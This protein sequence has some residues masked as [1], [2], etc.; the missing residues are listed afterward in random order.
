M[1]PSLI[2]RKIYPYFKSG[3]LSNKKLAKSDLN[4]IG[5]RTLR[6]TKL[7]LCSGVRF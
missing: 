3:N 6:G 7:V 5:A 2:L 1:I 4:T